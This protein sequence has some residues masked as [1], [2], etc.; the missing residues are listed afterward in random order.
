VARPPEARQIVYRLRL[1]EGA[2]PRQLPLILS[3][4]GPALSIETTVA[5]LDDDGR[6]WRILNVHGPEAEVAAALSAFEA[7]EPPH[8]AEKEVFGATRRRLI[9]WYKYRTTGG[10]ASSQTALA[11]R[12]LGRDTVVTDTTRAG[13]L[14]IRVLARP[15]GKVQEFLRAARRSA[16]PLSFELLYVGPPRESAMAQLSAPEE[17]TLRRAWDAGYFEVPGRIDVRDLAQA[18]SISASA[19]S[20]RLRRAVAK[21]VAA[22]LE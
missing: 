15:R 21:L 12:I 14:T 22:A 6:V 16:P 11:F 9:L 13:V 4:A 8:V 7:Y 17:E 10:A 2:P 18:L 5:H 19:A 1:P 3:R 20:Y